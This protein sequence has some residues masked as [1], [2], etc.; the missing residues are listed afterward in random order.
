ML[1]ES[2]TDLIGNTP[3][4]KIPQPVHNLR[5]IEIYAK[6][7]LFNPW[8]SVKDRTA[9][10]ILKPH[11]GSVGK[12]IVIENSSGNTAKALQM[13]TSIYGGNLKCVS[14]RIRVPEVKK[15]L[16]I[17]GTQINELPGK[18]DCY[19]P[20]D[21]N[22][23]N[24]YIGREV[25]KNPKKYIYSDQYFNDLNRQI[26]YQTTGVEIVEDLGHVDYFIGGLGTTGSTLG[27]A[28][29]I[30][31]YN[32]ELK[33]VGVIAEQ[34][35]Y[36]P[37]LRNR[38][39][40]LEVGLFKPDFYD[41]I[42]AVNSRDSLDSMMKLIKGVGLLAGPSTGASFWGAMKYLKDID[43][44]LTETKRAVFISC[45]RVEWYTSYI[46]DRRPEWFGQENSKNWSDNVALTVD[47]EVPVGNVEKWIGDNSPLI[48]DL[49]QPISFK[50]AH[51]SN[52]I[53]MPYDHINTVLNITNPFLTSQKILFVCPLGEKS[54]LVACYLRSSGVDAYSLQG[55]LNMWRDD[56]IPLER[57][58]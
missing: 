31:E 17:I 41:Q 49:R 3:L 34:D 8:G 35:D 13:I 58:T 28:E 24:V 5:H 11:L 37:G 15:V 6:L 7:E 39:E 50:M 36:I 10:G 53:N 1:I 54:A 47:C 21:P 12:K 44:K 52:S 19:D 43:S 45:D 14:N 33:V 25:A 23:P 46:E 30:K 18:S 22:D 40:V 51:I 38:D 48:V 42:V 20:N 9:F 26:H 27:A 16:Q 55:G 56:G 2:I 57:T 4:L 29:K 32:H